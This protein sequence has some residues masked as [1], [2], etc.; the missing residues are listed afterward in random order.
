[1]GK[2]GGKERVGKRGMNERVGERGWKGV[3]RKREG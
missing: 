3:A 2:S 1:V